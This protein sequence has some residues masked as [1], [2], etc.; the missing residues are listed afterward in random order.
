MNID[1]VTIT[2]ADDSVSPHELLLLSEAYPFVEWGIL[3]SMS[4]SG[5]KRFP[6]VDWVAGLIADARASVKLSVH[7]CG[8]WVREICDGKW[9]DLMASGYGPSLDGFDRCQLNFHGHSH[10]FPPQFYDALQTVAEN[11]HWQVI[12]QCD[13]VNDHALRTAIQHG[14]DAVPLFDMS[15]GAGV[16]PAMW[17][18]PFVG[19]YCGY[20]GGLGPD[21]I[22]E[23]LPLIEESSRGQPFWIDMETKVRSADD[24]KFDLDKVRRVLDSCAPHIREACDVA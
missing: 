18:D 16:L 2:G 23:Q 14:I 1:R 3:L 15:H 19:V 22:E 13:S 20:A 24:S 6:T 11:E 5:R 12:F 9:Q 4:S 7:I 17:P 8:Q 10:P 21:N